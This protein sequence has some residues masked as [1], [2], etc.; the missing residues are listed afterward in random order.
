MTTLFGKGVLPGTARELKNA[1]ASIK[2]N[3][4]EV[5]RYYVTGITSR[6]QRVEIPLSKF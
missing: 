3:I 6:W 1:Y 2:N 5:G 4:G